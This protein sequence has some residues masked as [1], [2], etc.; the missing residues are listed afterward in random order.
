[1]AAITV[2]HYSVDEGIQSRMFKEQLDSY[3]GSRVAS[4]MEGGPSRW[5]HR[6]AKKWNRTRDKL[7]TRPSCSCTYLIDPH[8]EQTKQRDY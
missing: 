1:M 5:H 8:G 6:V 4:A 7:L 2:L 3:A